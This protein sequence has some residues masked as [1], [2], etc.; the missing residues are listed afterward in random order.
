M[1]FHT[2]LAFLAGVFLICGSPGPNMLQVMATG[3]THGLRRAF[4]VM[5]GCFIPV[6]IMICA[7]VAGVGVIIQSFPALF[8]ALRYAGAT[9]LVWIGIQS[10]RAPVSEDPVGVTPVPGKN[11]FGRGLAVGVSN[12]KAML[13]ATAF[14]PQFLDPAAS[15]GVQCAIML[16]TFG[17]VEFSW[18]FVYAGLGSR[19]QKTLQRPSVQKKFNRA[20]GG[21]FIAFGL[22]MAFH[23]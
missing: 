4:P 20:T 8:D 13:F 2:W 6:F 11:L 23:L 22:W 9:Y 17:V 12:P 21:L 10:W 7:S 1:N 18:Y 16:A 19:L 15:Q 14:F 3:A 5:A